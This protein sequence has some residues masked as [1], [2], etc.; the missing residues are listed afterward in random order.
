MDK[1]FNGYLSVPSARIDFPEDDRKEIS[2]KIDEVLKS[3]MLTLGK[4][5]KEFE[6]NFREYVKTEHAVAVNSGTAALEIC[7]RASGIKNSSVV[8]PTNT[9]CATPAAVI[10]AGCKVIF[11]DIGDDMCLDPDSLQN[12]IKKDTKAAIIVH[13]AGNITE[14]INAIKDICNDKNILL[15]EDA[16]HAAGSS[17]AGVKAG[18]IGGCAAFSFYPTKVMTSGEGGMITANSKEICKK[19]LVL[20]DQGKE[21]F[22]SNNIVELGYNWRMSEISAIIGM[23]QLKRLDEFIEKRKKAAGIYNKVLKETE[24]IRPLVVPKKASPNCYKYVASLDCLAEGK[25]KREGL[26]KNMKEKFGVSLSGEVYD[27][28]CHLQPVFKNFFGNIG[29]P[30]S[31]RLCR[32][33]ICLPIYPQMKKE[34]AE[35]AADCLTKA[36]GDLR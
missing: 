1:R 12:S 36:V 29:L 2:R 26:K 3:G 16:A 7:L 28:P 35:Y 32:S 25:I 33:H 13:I 6:E 24:N 30:N 27:V 10:H 15:I 34:E 4:Y 14:N 18:N 5:T 20:R 9:F 8:V 31:E 19:A 22:N 23:Q 11:S 21:S 17:F